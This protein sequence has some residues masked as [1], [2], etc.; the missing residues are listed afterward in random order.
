MIITRCTCGFSVETE[1]TAEGYKI[2]QQ[3]FLDN[4]DTHTGSPLGS[5]LHMP[6]KKKSWLKNLWQ[7]LKDNRFIV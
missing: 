2:A 4:R 5:G 7:M 6:V 1:T 3:H